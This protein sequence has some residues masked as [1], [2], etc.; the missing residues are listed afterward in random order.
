MP[1]EEHG[2]IRFL[3]DRYRALLTPLGQALLWATGAAGLMML[4]GLQPAIAFFSFCAAVL[5]AGLV[6]GLP[7]RPRLQLT[8][9]L[10]PPVS[11]GDTLLYRW[12]WRTG[13]ST[14]R[15]R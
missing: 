3:S 12:W 7:F 11:A 14:P 6:A 9:R 15:A 4:W 5:L 1:P 13:A 8:R 10:P 2:F